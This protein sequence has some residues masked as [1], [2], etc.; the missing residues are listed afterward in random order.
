MEKT[1]LVRMMPD[2]DDLRATA[3]QRLGKEQ[4][5]AATLTLYRRIAP[6]YDV[7]YGALLQPGRQLA[8]T[9]LAPRAG[10]RILEIGV[11]TGLSLG[12]YPARCAVVGIDLSAPMLHRA[13]AR[14]RRDRLEQIALCRMDGAE[15]A[16]ANHTFDAIYAP[17]VINL[18]P[19]PLRVAR[20]MT[21]VCRPGGRVVLLN[22]FDHPGEPKTTVR[23]VAGLVASGLTGVNWKLR[24]FELLRDTPLQPESIE[25]VNVGRVSSV[26][27]CR[28]H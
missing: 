19:D 3:G 7:V 26:V 21:R 14:R 20:E 4:M 27:V 10:E 12:A 5:V 17:Y 15:L 18:V 25:A 28:R 8:M 9:R 6:F 11:G 23:R 2:V 1:T 16:F 24:L 13:N 22:H